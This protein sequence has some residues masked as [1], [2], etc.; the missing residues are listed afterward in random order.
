MT[1]SV[2]LLPQPGPADQGP[3]DQDLADR[4]ARADL[5]SALRD[6]GVSVIDIDLPSADAA[7]LSVRACAAILQ[8][9]PVSPMLVVAVGSGASL[10]PAVALAQRTAHRAVAGYVLIEPDSDPSAQDWP[11]APVLVVGV[12]GGAALHRA[13]LRGWDTAVAAEPSAIAEAILAR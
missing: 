10:L 3:A 1:G 8:A 5:L 11:D 13:R 6:R 2:V 9:G 12:E 7:P 4:D